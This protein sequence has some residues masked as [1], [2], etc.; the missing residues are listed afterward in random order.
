MNVAGRSRSL[1]WIGIWEDMN[2]ESKGGSPRDAAAG[3]IS[4][5]DGQSGARNDSR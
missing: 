2:T 4:R 5:R 3:A 1:S